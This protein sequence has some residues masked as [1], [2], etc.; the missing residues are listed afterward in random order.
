MFSVYC[1][2][3]EREVL[4]SVSNIVGM[5][6]TAEGIEVHWRCRCGAAGTWLTGARRSRP[7]TAAATAA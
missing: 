3:H 2:G 5:S 7:G 1:P 6:N 4:L